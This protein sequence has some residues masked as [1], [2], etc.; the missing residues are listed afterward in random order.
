MIT[1]RVVVG[2]PLNLISVR[3]KQSCMALFA[4]TDKI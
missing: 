2:L 4:D 3:W 1:G